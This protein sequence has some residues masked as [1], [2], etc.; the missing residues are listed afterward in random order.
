MAVVV[1]IVIKGITFTKPYMRIDEIVEYFPLGRSKVY[2]LI[3][4][5]VFTAHCEKGAKVKGISIPTIEIKAYYDKIEVP[6]EKW[7]E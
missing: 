1:G 6:K 3:R 7:Q 5:G 4:D 2:E